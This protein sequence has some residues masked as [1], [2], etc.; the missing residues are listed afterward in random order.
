MIKCRENT[1]KG[2]DIWIKISSSLKNK[3]DWVESVGTINITYI[4]NELL[5][6]SV[7]FIPSKTIDLLAI[8]ILEEIKTQIKPKYVEIVVEYANTQ[9]FINHSMETDIDD[10][11]IQEECK[12]WE[13]VSNYRFSD[14]KFI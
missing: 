2:K 3:G 13:A 6:N 12:G 9:I 7:E 8:E 10:E 4:P 5:I 14:P 11:E 1:L